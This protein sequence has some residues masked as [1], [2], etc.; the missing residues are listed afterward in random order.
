MNRIVPVGQLKAAEAIDEINDAIEEREEK[1]F[2][3]AK[4][5]YVGG[6]KDD[7]HKL[8]EVSLALKLNK[9]LNET[10][11]GFRH[12]NSTFEMLFCW[13]KSKINKRLPAKKKDCSYEGVL[14]EI[15]LK[16]LIVCL[17]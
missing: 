5:G 16:R 8:R 1:M 9:N 17:N 3:A 4:D 15:K 7:T 14:Q 10:E 13:N 11:F 2:D 6:V 12:F